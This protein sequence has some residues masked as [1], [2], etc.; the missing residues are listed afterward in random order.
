MT[1]KILGPEG[2]RR[3]KRLWLVPILVTALAAVFFVAGAQAV[4]DLQFQL[5]GDA[6]AATGGG[7]SGQPKDW[8]SFF[9]SSGGQIAGSLG[10]AG[11]VGCFNTSGFK[12]DF[13]RTSSGAFD[14]TDL[15]TFATGS[16]DI[17]NLT[18]G[19]QCAGSN[20]ITPKDTLLNVYST[21]YIDTNGDEILYM[22]LERWANN[23]AGDVGF[24]FLQDP[25]VGCEATG[26]GGGGTAAFTGNH[27]DGD[28][29][30]VAEFSTGGTVTTIKAFKWVGGANGSLDTT[31]PIAS[32][33]DCRS[34]Q[35][36]DPICGTANNSSNGVNGDIT[37]PWDTTVKGGGSVLHTAEF[38]EAGLNLTSQGVANEC[39][40]NVLA[41]TRSS[42]S[43]TATLFDF[44]IAPL[45][46]CVPTLA[47]QAS[48]NT[49]NPVVP[50]SPVHDT[51]TIT[52]QGGNNPPDPTGTVTFFLC[53]PI[54]SGDCSTGGANVGTGN[55]VGGAN[56]TDGIATAVSPDVNT[57]VSPLAAGRY[58]FRA[59]WPG[60]NLYKTPLSGTNSTTE[61]FAVKDTSSTTTAQRW[62]PNDTATVTTG[63]GAAAS[64]SVTFTLYSS[65]NCT[66]TVLGTFTD[67][68]APFETS[69]TTVSTSSTTISWRAVFTPSDPNAV[70][71]STSHCETS[72]LTINN[73]IGS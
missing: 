40:A 7:P 17:L 27:R 54:A 48:A 69:N 31:T 57:V 32:G 22:G 60:D 61:C 15:S 19:W 29:L 59:T 30:V 58:C 34:T 18:P 3:R 20:N 72:T 1:Q 26:T 35:G 63:S 45:N 21:V 14:S 55:L 12:K 42:P 46:P 4:H 52:V 16:K 6:R 43:P 5:D 73:D 38:F 56:T 53:G 28:I 71:G 23:G 67:T 11:C 49:A 9:N 44:A 70:N 65:G 51:A 41:D 8:D 33:A 25:A 50:G 66:G 37:V 39:F 64:G 62:L 68:S 24:W 2:S 36:P 47:T 13:L 10:S